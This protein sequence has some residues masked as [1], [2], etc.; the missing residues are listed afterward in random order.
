MKITKRALL[1]ELLSAVQVVC[2]TV[3]L[4]GGAFW[5]RA[6]VQ[7]IVRTQIMGDNKLVAQQMSKLI[8]R[9]DF[10]AIEF[11]TDDWSELQSL[12]EDVSLPNDGYMCIA[13]AQDGRL[14]CHPQM[15]T[16]PELRESD[17]FSSMILVGEARSSIR[18]TLARNETTQAQQFTG[19]IG[20]GN[21]TEVVS[22]ASL[23]QLDSVL[24][25]HQSE[26][27][28]RK[29][30]NLLLLPLGGIALVV[31]F[32]LIFVTK[33]ASVGILNCYENR[34]AELNEGLEE[35]VRVRTRALTK[36]RDAVIFGLAK[37]SE[38]RDND[39]GEHLER[40]STYV[41]ILARHLATF[42]TV[43]DDLIE[44][45]GLAS[46]LHDIGKV[47][48]PDQVLL[49]P[50]RLTVEER[51][52]METHPRVGQECLEAIEGQLGED[53]FLS[54]ATEICAY[55]HERWDGTG[56]P[57]GLAGADIPLSARLVA[58]ADVYDAL[59]SRRP[60]KESMSHSK[61]RK[62]I[63]EGR[64]THFDP[65]VV[66]AFVAAEHEFETLFANPVDTASVRGVGENAP[67]ANR[68]HDAAPLTV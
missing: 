7:K 19:L 28:F 22:V 2:L 35:T 16:N 63:M 10:S 45:I 27:G 56:Y 43:G 33:K 61:A 3:A 32:A 67:A 60:Y 25:V 62:I 57:N 58:L 54:L 8:D 34:I 37:L 18:E 46:S 15:R 17:V 20:G 23:P 14:L 68:Q 50:G 44:D 12:V 49:K 11:G 1:V 4:L 42:A 30:V 65:D 13:D 36:T 47:G 55:H 24:F 64:G 38:S 31:G 5:V 26:K 48:V 9:S 53:N 59:R 51:L 29:A 66:D 39:T 21:A 40:I 41:T 52:I 6:S